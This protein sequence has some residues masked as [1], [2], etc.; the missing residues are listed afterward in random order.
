M[1]WWYGGSLWMAIGG[2][3]MMVLFWGGLIVLAVWLVR[4]TGRGPQQL[5]PMETL[6][7][8]LASGDINREQY[9]QTRKALQ[10]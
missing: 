10:G 1:M 3:L 9:E 8:R 7:R 5:D 2:G 4:G 6:K